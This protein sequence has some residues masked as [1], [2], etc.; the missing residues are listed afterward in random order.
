MP[1]AIVT[2]A[3]RGQTPLAAFAAKQRHSSAWPGLLL[4]R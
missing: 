1:S 4:P 2:V 3:N